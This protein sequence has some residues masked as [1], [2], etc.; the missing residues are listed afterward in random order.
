MKRAAALLLALWAAPLAAA[1]F[2]AFFEPFRAAVV[3][4]DARA[5]AAKTRTPFLL[6]GR[7]LDA[8]AFEAA[9]PGLFDAPIRACFR[10]APVVPEGPQ[11]LVFCRGTI[12]VFAED[13]AG[14]RF[15]E[16]GVDD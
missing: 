2:A 4:G 10:T 1:D 12:F 11:R 7:M 14:W 15:T 16:I 13:G 5:I 6:E 9:A 8:K 3:K